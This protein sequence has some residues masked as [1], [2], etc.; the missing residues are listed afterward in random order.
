MTTGVNDR[1]SGP[2]TAAAGQTVFG[3]D[4]PC[5][6]ATR[7]LVLRRRTGVVTALLLN[8]HFTATLGSGGA[9]TLSAGA[10]L[11]DE[12]V[13]V[14]DRDISRTTQFNGY[15]SLPPAAMEAELDAITEIQQEFERDTQYTLKR[16][17]FENSYDVNGG[18][19]VGVSPATAPGEL[20]TY[21][22]W[23]TAIEGGQDVNDR[24]DNEIAN[25]MAGDAA[26]A[27]Q[28]LT[29]TNNRI[30]ADLVLRELVA[31][32]AAVTPAG[33][34][35]V[36]ADL[37]HLAS[38]DTTANF[39]AYLKTPYRAGNF[40]LV[41]ASAYAALIAA[42]SNKIL[43]VPSTHNP[44][45]AWLRKG[46]PP[47]AGYLELDWAINDADTDATAA[48]NRCVALGTAMG[49][50]GANGLPGLL[51]ML[52]PREIQ[53]N[54]SLIPF[55][56]NLS[57]RGHKGASAVKF[58]TPSVVGPMLRA[59][60]NAGAVPNYVHENTFVDDIVFD[61]RDREFKYWL[62]KADGTPVTDPEADYVMGTG[63]LASGI[64]GVSLTAT[65]TDGRVTGVAINSGGSGWNGHPTHP[66]LPNQV[67]LK[68]TGGNPNKI[69]YGYATISGG[70]LT[71]VVI[72]YPGYDYQS[73]PTVTTA[74]GYADILLLLEPS[75]DRRN[76]LGYTR[77]NDLVMQFVQVDRGHV[78]GC[79]FLGGSGLVQA[80]GCR[81][82]YI[83][84]NRTVNSGKP[85][86]PNFNFTMGDY[87]PGATRTRSDR[88]F[89]RNNV[90]ED[91]VRVFCAMSGSGYQEISRNV[92]TGAS[93]FQLGPGEAGTNN[94]RTLITAN[95]CRNVIYRNYGAQMGE[96]DRCKNVQVI[97]NMFE[98]C[99]GQAIGLLAPKGCDFVGNI[100]RNMH[101]DTG[102][103]SA[104]F[105][106]ESERLHEG[107]GGVPQI[108]K[109]TGAD[110]PRCLILSNSGTDGIQ[111][112]IFDNETVLDNRIVVGGF[113]VPS[114]MAFFRV[115]A[116][117]AEIG[118]NVEIKN[119][120]MLRP[121]T[122]TDNPDIALIHP[123]S[124]ID[125]PDVMEPRMSLRVH[126]IPD[127]DGS[128]AKLVQ[129]VIAPGATGTR[130]IN[131][132]FPPKRVQ[133]Q[134][135][136]AAG[137][138]RSS[139]AFLYWDR[140]SINGAR[141]LG[142][143]LT[144]EEAAGAQYFADFTDRIAKLVNSAGV[145][146]FSVSFGK[147]TVTGFEMT[148]NVSTI[149]TTITMVCEP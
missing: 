26:V 101:R 98:D 32:H 80:L 44:A 5:A 115:G 70:T 123:Q 127:R 17:Y 125:Y 6:D 46:V 13:I 36:A 149:G 75:V 110:Q 144:Y 55:V 30:A 93:L 57:V 7:L 117:S 112:T 15:R 111:N 49:R 39:N 62:S 107:Y 50:C 24:I 23:L 95:Y 94:G 85:D 114:Y 133:L 18:R 91:C 4:F 63:A 72:E 61:S 33:G 82:F 77:L 66:Y 134:C 47:Q 124:I 73:V 122:W 51:L 142:Q 54:T 130:V 68:F 135:K 96:M 132:G 65:V 10:E 8:V 58:G 56:S 52:P 121:V 104:G 81:D 148:I 145:E 138:G 89:L 42:D 38:L 106:S 84:E 2:Y 97:R 140:A 136:D 21:E 76:E 3:Y 126:N 9:V 59:V 105:T 102:N 118:R 41:D 1:I 113:E 103:R 137:N 37:T 53:W 28:V 43:I 109:L 131:V 74:G 34:L 147:W 64:S 139:Q 86:N 90:A 31:N 27:Q 69:A 116:G 108:F 146:L 20:I 22:Q 29:E 40:M 79:T 19:I 60:A 87:V 48:F 14:G 67:R 141:V 35:A 88:N 128:C 100:Y 78:R 71:S 92:V 45:Y 83:E 16:S 12:I 143:S 25:R 11:G 129:E 119:I 120:R 99:D